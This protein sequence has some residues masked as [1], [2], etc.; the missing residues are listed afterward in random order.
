MRQGTVPGALG[1]H[2]VRVVMH[3]HPPEVVVV[4]QVHPPEVV[5]LCSEP[6]EISPTI[7]GKIHGARHEKFHAVQNYELIGDAG[8]EDHGQR[9]KQQMRGIWKKSG[10]DADIQ[11]TTEIRMTARYGFQ[12]TS[13][14]GGSS[15]DIWTSFSENR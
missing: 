10:P 3:M 7:F 8:I 14:P 2:L 11:I 4:M 6:Q 5:K 15:A 9:S 1:L 13:S 12:H